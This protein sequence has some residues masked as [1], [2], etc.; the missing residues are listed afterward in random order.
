MRMTTTL[1]LARPG[2]RLTLQEH[3]Y[4]QMKTLLMTGEMAPGE[5]LTV[6]AVA[7]RTGTSPMPVREAFRR[8]ASERALEI[9]PNGTARVRLLSAGQCRELIEIRQELEGLAVRRAAPAMTRPGLR[10]LERRNTAM[11]KAL[12]RRDFRGYARENQAFHFLLYAAAGR[13]ELLGL[14]EGLWLQMGPTLM[15]RAT[16]IATGE[17]RQPG[18]LLDDHRKILAALRD[19]DAAAAERALR[20]DLAKIPL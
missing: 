4:R 16:Q 8:L 5:Q 20:G 7:E 13:G 18:D 6:R 3:V 2:E 12:A 11:E 1:P 15:A 19:G 17:I 14:I 10:A 9:M